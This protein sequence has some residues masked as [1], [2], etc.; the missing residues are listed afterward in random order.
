MSRIL[1]QKGD[2]MGHPS[3]LLTFDKVAEQLVAELIFSDMENQLDK[4][5]CANQQDL[6]L[7]HYLAKMITKYYLILMR[8]L[9]VRSIQSLQPY[10]TGRKHFLVSVPNLLRKL[11]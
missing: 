1:A 5:Q 9:R 6:S 10:L 2:F 8:G 4:S 3:G 11:L 7:Q